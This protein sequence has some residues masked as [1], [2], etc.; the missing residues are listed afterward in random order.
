MFLWML[1]SFALV[2]GVVTA[3]CAVAAPRAERRARRSFYA[4]LGFDEDLISILMAQKGS[5]SVQLAR[6]RQAALSSGGRPQALRG[7]EG[8]QRGN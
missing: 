8:S 2:L 3:V 5:V 4:S 1:P 6:V 7:A